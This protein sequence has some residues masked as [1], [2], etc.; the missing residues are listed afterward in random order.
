MQTLPIRRNAAACF[1]NARLDAGHP[2]LAIRRHGSPGQVRP[3][4][5]RPSE[6]FMIFSRDRIL[7]THVGSLPRNE[8][9]S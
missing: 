7:T 2:H 1:A 8:K 9:L 5:H 3:W 6:F 4:L